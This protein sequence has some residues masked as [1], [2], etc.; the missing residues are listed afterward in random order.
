[1]NLSGK[2]FLLSGLEYELCV[3]SIIL[4]SRSDL[5]NLFKILLGMNVSDSSSIIMYLGDKSSIKLN[6]SYSLFSPNDIK[7]SPSKLITL[8]L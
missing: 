7:L 3:V 5:Y 2:N 8:F 6:N 4:Y 1:M